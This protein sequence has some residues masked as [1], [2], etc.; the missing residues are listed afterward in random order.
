MHVYNNGKL[1]RECTILTLTFAP[2][3]DMT[4]PS[5]KVLIDGKRISNQTHYN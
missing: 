4:I 1:Q 5:Y 3:K 2:K